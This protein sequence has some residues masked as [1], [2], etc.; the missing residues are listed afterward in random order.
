MGSSSQKEGLPEE[1]RGDSSWDYYTRPLIQLVGG[2][3]NHEGN[4]EV[5]YNGSWGTVCDDEWDNND[6]KVVCR[7]LR[8]R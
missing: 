7:M 8:Y 2:R 3:N 1:E 4:V 6:A 5:Y